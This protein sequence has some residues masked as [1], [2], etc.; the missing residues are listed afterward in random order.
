MGQ[1]VAPTNRLEKYVG[2]D[3]NSFEMIYICSTCANASD[4]RLGTN[5]PSP[6]KPSAKM[7]VS[8]S[9]KHRVT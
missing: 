8:W 4:M 1:I 5:L 3:K 6:T 2:R 9:V 7:F